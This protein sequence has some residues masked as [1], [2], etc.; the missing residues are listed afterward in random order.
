MESMGTATVSS[1]FPAVTCPAQKNP[2]RP[3]HPP[4]K[5]AA[6]PGFPID[7]SYSMIVS[8]VS[9]SRAN[10]TAP[11]IMTGTTFLE[12]GAAGRYRQ[13]AGNSINP[14]FSHLFGPSSVVFAKFDLNDFSLPFRCQNPGWDEKRVVSLNHHDFSKFN[15]TGQAVFNGHPVNVWSFFSQT[16]KFFSNMTLMTSEVNN[17]LVFMHTMNSTDMIWFMTKAVNIFSYNELNPSDPC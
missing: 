6:C 15:L 13:D 3:H 4:R 10:G 17:R 7:S 9:I 16:G 11:V 5:A 8:E 14:F 12:N 2:I 1:F